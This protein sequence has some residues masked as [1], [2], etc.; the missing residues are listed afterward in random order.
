MPRLSAAS[1]LSSTT[2]T[3][4]SGAPAARSFDGAGAWTTA[5]SAIGS[6][7]VNSHPLPGPSLAASMDP[8]CRWTSV[9]ARVSPIPSP[10]CARVPVATC[11]NM[12][13]TRCSIGLALGDLETI[14]SGARV[15]G[16]DLQLAEL[17]DFLRHDIGIAW[18]ISSDPH[19]RDAGLQV[20]LDL[21]LRKVMAKQCL[22]CVSAEDTTVATE[23]IGTLRPPYL[24]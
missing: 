20:L 11:V 7:T 19:S 22:I 13:N 14:C 1:W 4:R 5:C 24:A 3:R 18:L 21:D 23:C 9:L 10:P 17:E 6:F 8:P 12:L 16:I 15:H 2:N